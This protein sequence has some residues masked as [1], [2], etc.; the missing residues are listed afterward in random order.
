MADILQAT[1]SKDSLYQT[2]FR[3]VPVNEYII[4]K[5]RGQEKMATVLQTIFSYAFYWMKCICFA[6]AGLFEYV[7]WDPL[8]LH[9][10]TLI[11]AWIS[12]YMPNKV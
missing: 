1:S 6:N 11:S 4:L 10:L 3:Y 5:Y 12:I 8:Y 7:P 9:G 2:T